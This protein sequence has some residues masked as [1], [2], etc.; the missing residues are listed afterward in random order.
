MPN[1]NKNKHIVHWMWENKNSTTMCLSSF[2]G[3]KYGE[4]KKNSRTRKKI[5]S[6]FYAIFKRIW[7]L[8]T[9]MC[10]LSLTKNKI[11]QFDINLTTVNKSAKLSRLNINFRMLNFKIAPHTQFFMDT[12]T[13]NNLISGGCC[14]CVYFLLFSLKWMKVI[15]CQEK[16]FVLA[17]IQTLQNCVW[18]LFTTR[19]YATMWC[20]FCGWYSV[21]P[22]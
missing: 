19:K 20:L 1:N 14:C 12:N 13:G 5:V 18:K 6:N 21:Q 8:C 15:R 4:W 10:H 3:V 16:N 17:D 22:S 7:C 2:N 11:T 9:L